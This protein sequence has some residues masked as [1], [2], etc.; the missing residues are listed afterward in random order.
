MS[1][2]ISVF[3]P[4]TRVPALRVELS[5]QRSADGERYAQIM[6]A[7]G[8]PQTAWGSV[9]DEGRDRELS[10]FLLRLC[11]DLRTPLRAIRSHAELLLKASD[12]P[13]N[14]DAEQRLGFIVSGAESMRL[15]V[16]GLADYSLALR[17]EQSSF[18]PTQAGVLVRLVLAKLRAELERARAEVTYDALPR[19]NGDPDRL[20]QVFESVILNAIRYRGTEAPRIHISTEKQDGSWRFAVRDNGPGIEPEYLQR[21]FK[22]FERLRGKGVPGAGLGLAIAREIVSRHGGTMWAES[23]LGAGSTFFFTVPAA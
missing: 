7:T 11:H 23:Q 9:P 15:L 13:A 21:I 14:T 17:V 12:P 10:D 1:S 4:I 5:I 20:S 16:D 22:P 8:D 18:Q 3:S 19:V 6:A 2:G